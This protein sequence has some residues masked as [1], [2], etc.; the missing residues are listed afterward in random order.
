MAACCSSNDWPSLRPVADNRA[1]ETSAATCGHERQ[2]VLCIPHPSSCKSRQL[3]LATVLQPQRA[4]TI[5]LSAG[6]LPPARESLQVDNPTRVRAFLA[7]SVARRSGFV[8][9]VVVVGR[10][11]LAYGLRHTAPSAC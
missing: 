11:P 5:T 3:P 10:W 2:G 4:T 6:A 8:H 1:S 7:D 9:L